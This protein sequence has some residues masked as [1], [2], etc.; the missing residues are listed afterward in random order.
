MSMPLT[1]LPLIAD[2]KLED[3][4]DENVSESNVGLSSPAR[5]AYEQRQISTKFVCMV[6]DAPF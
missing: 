2:V 3:V 4:L 1:A 5:P 6:Y